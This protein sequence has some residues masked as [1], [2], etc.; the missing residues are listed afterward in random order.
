[1]DIAYDHLR[2]MLLNGSLAQGSR[3]NEARTAREIGV[4]R[5]PIR[6]AIRVLTR[7]GLLTFA[8]NLGCFVVRLSAARIAEVLEMRRILEPA[9]YQAIFER[10]GA[11]FM[12]PLFAA[13]REMKVAEVLGDVP[14]AIAAHS[15]LHGSIYEAAGPVFAQQWQGLD[16]LL[17]MYLN[18]GTTINALP[19]LSRDHE[20]LL[21]LLAEGDGSAALRDHIDQHRASLPWPIGS[22]SRSGDPR[23]RY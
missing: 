21:E 4:S 5:G 10:R 17:Q 18:A 8:P 11:G 15:R 19:A 16:P 2:E 3:L 7:E 6:E 12:G 13:L 9:A 1:M 23:A 22:D 20:G 14:G